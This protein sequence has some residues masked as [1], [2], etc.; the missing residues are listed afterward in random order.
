[1]YNKDML[2]VILTAFLL[3]TSAFLTFGVVFLFIKIRQFEKKSHEIQ[4]SITDFIVPQ[5][6]G[7]AS[8]LANLTAAIGQT[9]GQSVAVQLK[10]MFMGKESAISRAEQGV[11]GEMVTKVASESIPGLGLFLKGFPKLS[12]LAGKYPDEAMAII[13]QFMP[14]A[15]NNGHNHIN[16]AYDE[17]VTRV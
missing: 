2:N 17:N 4:Q 5:A 14:K 13:Q 15:G 10:T 7:E 9:I 8:G 6:E 12:K 16:R 11:M 3:A 1:M